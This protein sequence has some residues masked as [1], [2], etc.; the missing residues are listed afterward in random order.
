MGKKLLQ[1]EKKN[2]VAGMISLLKQDILLRED[3]YAI[4]DLMHSACV[5]EQK[6]AMAGAEAGDGEEDTPE[7]IQAYGYRQRA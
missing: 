5:R 3:A 7:G 1:A 4:L 6:R 2:L